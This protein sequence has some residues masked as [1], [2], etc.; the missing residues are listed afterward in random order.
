MSKKIELPQEPVQADAP[1][2]PETTVDDVLH[3][4]EHAGN[5]GAYVF[6]G[7]TGKRIPAPEAPP[8]PTEK[9]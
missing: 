3:H 6:D 8:T 4:D 5:G 9:E 2:P 1:L 7:S